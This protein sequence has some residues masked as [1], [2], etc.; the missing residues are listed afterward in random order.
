MAE[1]GLGG[2]EFF[3]TCGNV[4]QPMRARQFCDNRVTY[5]TAIFATG[6]QLQDATASLRR[7]AAEKKQAVCKR[8]VLTPLAPP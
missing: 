5:R 2:L 7:P 6:E 1:K 4:D 3:P 8:Y